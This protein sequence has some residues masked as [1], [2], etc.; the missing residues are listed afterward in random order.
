MSKKTTGVL[1]VAV[2]SRGYAYMAYNMA[3]SI[4]H[5]DRT[6][7]IHLLADECFDDIPPSRRSVFDS[8]SGPDSLDF[9][10]DGRIDPGKLKTRLYKYLPFDNTLYLDV[11][12]LAMRSLT[13]LLQTLSSDERFFITSLQGKGTQSEKINYSEWAT[14]EFIAKTFGLKPSQE[15]SAIQSSYAFVRKCREAKSFFNEV[16]K[17]YDKVKLS[18]LTYAWGGTMPDELLFSGVISAKDMSVDGPGDVIFFG[19]RGVTFDPSDIEGNYDILS[20]Y[21]RASGRSMTAP[22]FW[23]YYDMLLFAWNRSHRA[24]DKLAQPHIYKSVIVKQYK[25]ANQRK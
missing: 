25:H 17:S 6:V 10:T 16:E 22:R 1:L 21:G 20:V 19:T 12:G 8:W 14:N 3:Y 13:P 23:E 15:I 5:H 18:E 2:G 11:D 24:G 4:K 9:R 7:K